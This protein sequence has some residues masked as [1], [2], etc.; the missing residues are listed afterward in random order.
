MDKKTKIKIKKLIEKTYPYDYVNQK[1]FYEKQ[2]ESYQFMNNLPDSEF[3]KMIAK[4]FP[5]DFIIQKDYY[6]EQ[7]EAYE[8]MEKVLD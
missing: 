1:K 4:E 2:T 3:K 8:F 7:K 5:N 6:I